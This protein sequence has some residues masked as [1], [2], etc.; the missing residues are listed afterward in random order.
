M[1]DAITIKAQV[2]KA[3]TTADGAL[4]VYMDVFGADETQIAYMTL[5][6][7]RQESI[8]FTPEPCDEEE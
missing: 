7:H 1:S 5:L 4:R 2:V 8:R 6:A 3:Q